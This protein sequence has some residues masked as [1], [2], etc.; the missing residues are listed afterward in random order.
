MTAGDTRV[1]KAGAKAAFAYRTDVQGL[2][3]LAVALVLWFHLWPDTLP[4][5]FIGVDI[6]FVISGF[7]ITSHLLLHPP[8]GAADLMLFW[9]R[10]VRRL[11]PAALFVV[12]TALI[13][14]RLLAPPEHS[15]F[16]GLDGMITILYLQ[17]WQLAETSEDP[18]NA[19][20]VPPVVQHFWSLSVE[21]QF[22]AVWPVLLF[23]A[24]VLAACKG[25]RM[26]TTATW[27][28]AGV[29]AASLMFSIFYTA[30]NPNQAYFA[31]P[32]RIWELAAG[33]LLAAFVLR[34]A[35]GGARPP[36][37]WLGELAVWGGYAVLV[38]TLITFDHDRRFPGAIAL[39]PVLATLAIIL[40]RRERG[41][42]PN[43][44][45]RFR[46]VQYLGDLSYS[47]YLWHVPL[48]V[49][50]PFV[51]GGPLRIRDGVAIS[52]ASVLLAALTK[53]HV[54]DRF[55]FGRRRPAYVPTGF[56][57]QARPVPVAAQRVALGAYTR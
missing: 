49:L 27:L 8:S 12:L 24:V 30:S 38:L 13:A 5:G 25:W 55:R 7:L 56:P 44:L 54:E 35:Q 34:R 32:T 53:R 6:F 17:N 52:V 31:T 23:G 48:I 42:N 26:L 36:P 51:T 10:R 2:R 18:L 29:I 19:A 40:G 57:D 11:L 47:I 28:M 1:N 15:R 37:A 39:A 14:A 4:G 45:L 43:C 9:G 22:Y 46:P 21:E 20:Q 16:G 33:G 50:T 3:A 41:A